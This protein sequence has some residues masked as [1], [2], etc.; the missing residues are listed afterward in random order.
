MLRFSFIFYFFIISILSVILLF[1]RVVYAEVWSE[2]SIF[3]LGMIMQAEVMQEI[4]QGPKEAIV[5]VY[6]VR[7]S[8][9]VNTTIVTDRKKGIR[10][11]R[12][13]RT[14]RHTQ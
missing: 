1:M 13:R 6:G 3:F 2:G 7:R 10:R 11:Y 14:S 12:K 9:T 5:I 4:S 8:I